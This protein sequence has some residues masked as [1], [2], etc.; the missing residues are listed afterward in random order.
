MAEQFVLLLLGEWTALGDVCQPRHNS[1]VSVIFALLLIAEGNEEMPVGSL[2]QFVLYVGF[3][4]AQHEGLDA[5]V[6]SIEVAIAHRPASLV[7]FVI[8]AVE[9]EERAEQ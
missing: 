7:Q 5:V 3:A 1:F 8:F 9:P 2:R 6:K 4:A